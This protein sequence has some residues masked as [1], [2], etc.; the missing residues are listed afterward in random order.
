VA[1]LLPEERA[2]AVRAALASAGLIVTSD[3]TILECDRVLLRA[4]GAGRLNEAEA[5][6]RRAILQQAASHWAV[7]SISSEVMDRAR[8]PF[9]HEPVRTLDALHL[10]LA[11]SARSMVPDLALLSL[12]ARVRRS[13]HAMGFELIPVSAD[14]W[15]VSEPRS[16]RTRRAAPRTLGRRS[17]AGS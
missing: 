9:P 10:A 16:R 5:A 3:L 17:G 7:L 15:S 1:W 4:L 8:R 11:A 6:D 2:S 13:G 14:E 12:D